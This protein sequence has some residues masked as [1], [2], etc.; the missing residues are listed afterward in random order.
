MRWRHRGVPALGTA[1]AARST[2]KDIVSRLARHPHRRHPC[3]AQLLLFSGLQ[4]DPAFGRS[5]LQPGPTRLPAPEA[6][7]LESPPKR[8]KL[9]LTTLMAFVGVAGQVVTPACLIYC[10]AFASSFTGLGSLIEMIPYQPLIGNRTIPFGHD[11]QWA[12]AFRAEAT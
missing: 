1:R 10:F 7:S 12:P 8:H 6:L 2:S 9:L 5:L 3:T 11:D 4:A